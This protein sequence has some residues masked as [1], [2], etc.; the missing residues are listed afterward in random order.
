MLYVLEGLGIEV[1][2]CFSNGVGQKLARG[3]DSSITEEMKLL[4]LSS[5]TH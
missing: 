5:P 2:S 4:R 1:G 3:L